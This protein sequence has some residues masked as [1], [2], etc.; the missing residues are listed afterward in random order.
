MFCP[1]LST[2]TSARVSS[3]VL[4]FLLEGL[5]RVSDPSLASMV[6]SLSTEATGGRLRRFSGRMQTKLL[7]PCA[8]CSHCFSSSVNGIV[9]SH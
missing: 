9:V 4:E 3:A 7:S 2:A 6:L 8:K 1:A 5:I